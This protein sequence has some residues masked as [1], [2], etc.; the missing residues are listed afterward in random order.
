[1]SELR[2]IAHLNDIANAAPEK[3]FGDYIRRELERRRHAR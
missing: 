2:T 3:G 1:L